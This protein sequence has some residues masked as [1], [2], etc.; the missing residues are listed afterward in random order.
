MNPSI[1]LPR[2]TREDG[3]TTSI[4]IVTFFANSNLVISFVL[5]SRQHVKNELCTQFGKIILPLSWSHYLSNVLLKIPNQ[6]NTATVF[7]VLLQSKKL[8]SNLKWNRYLIAVQFF[9]VTSQDTSRH[10]RHQNLSCCR[11]FL[12]ACWALFIVLTSSIAV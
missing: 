10:Q 7:Y 11:F 9:H 1:S 12:Q 3:E 5:W 2:G 6:Q 8:L 4:M